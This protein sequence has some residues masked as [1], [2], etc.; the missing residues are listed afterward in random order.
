MSTDDRKILKGFGIFIGIFIGIIVAIWLLVSCFKVVG[1][2][3]VAVITSFGNVSREVNSGMVL[4]APWPFEKIYAFDA[5]TQKDNTDAAASSQDLQDVN[6]TLVTNYRLDDKR[7]GDLY[8]T[9]GTDYK[10]R[11]IDPAIQESVKATSAKFTAQ[12]LIQKRTEVKDSALATLK[13]RL[14]PRGIVIEDISITNI[15][16][17]E[18]FTKAIES[19]QVAAQEAE[20]SKYAI[21][22][23]KNNAQAKIED[24]KGQAQANDLL[25]QSISA[26]TLESKAIDKWDGKMPLAV[27][28]ASNIYNIPLSR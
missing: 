20:K 5:K 4:K 6:F 15:K 16:F 12:N 10:A 18:E 19:K 26:E 1:V 28:N 21:E 23:A 3:K 2:G 17:S 14:E 27:G 25:K 11:I 9:V 13:Q 24:A 22:A 7:I 8:K